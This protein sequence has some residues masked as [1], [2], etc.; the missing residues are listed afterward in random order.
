MNTLPDELILAILSRLPFRDAWHAGLAHKRMHALLQRAAPEV[1]GGWEHVPR[2]LPGETWLMHLAF[3]YALNRARAGFRRSHTLDATFC[4]LPLARAEEWVPSDGGLL[5]TPAE[6]HPVEGHPASFRNVVQVAVAEQAFPSHKHHTFA[7]V[8]DARG[9]VFSFGD[10]EYGNLGFA[11]PTLADHSLDHSRVHALLHHVPNLPVCAYVAASYR[12]SAAVTRAGE[13]YVWGCNRDARIGAGRDARV[14][15]PVRCLHLPLPAMHVALG[16]Q[17]M[18]V[19]TREGS[20]YGCGS[21]AYGQLGLGSGHAS[22]SSLTHVPL[23]GPRTGPRTGPLTGRVTQAAAGDM[24]SVLLLVTGDL[25]EAGTSHVDARGAVQRFHFTP[26]TPVAGLPARDAAR[27]DS[28]FKDVQAVCASTA[29]IST[30]GALYVYGHNMWGSYAQPTLVSAPEPTTSCH[31]T[32]RTGIFFTGVSGAVYQ[33]QHGLR[34]AT[35]VSACE[36]IRGKC[37][38]RFAASA[39]IIAALA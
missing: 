36:Q 24:H 19:V 15:Q 37:T 10:N 34:R 27:D 6:G 9:R 21:N 5:D 33:F 3:T 2:R 7:L 25:L 16:L 17:H 29:L 11:P 8:L 14:M 20:V 38:A 30:R 28:C 4:R 18:L 31:L 13:L 26:C 35:P 32:P 22:F 23:T 1:A 39:K 12:S